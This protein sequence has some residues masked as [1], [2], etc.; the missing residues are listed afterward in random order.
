[1]NQF[2]VNGSAVN[3]PETNHAVQC[4]SCC[5]VSSVLVFPRCFP[6]TSSLSS[7]HSSFLFR[8]FCSV[9]SACPCRT[10]GERRRTAYVHWPCMCLLIRCK[11]GSLWRSQG[12][13]STAVQPCLGGAR[14]GGAD[15]SHCCCCFTPRCTVS[16]CCSVS[17]P[18]TITACRHYQLP[19]RGR[20]FSRK[21]TFHG[22]R[23]GGGGGEREGQFDSLLHFI[24]VAA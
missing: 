6:G 16:S 18:N 11:M 22:Q 20:G 3:P 24:S 12:A 2:S 21:L 13:P 23:D 9:C 4:D 5:S 7:V 8:L 17:P 15:W 10:T 19:E 1:M 14:G